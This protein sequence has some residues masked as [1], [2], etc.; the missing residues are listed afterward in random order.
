MMKKLLFVL[1]LFA[2]YDI[3]IANE[4]NQKMNFR[5]EIAERIH[6]ECEEMDYI[7]FY[8]IYFS[9]GKIMA[10]TEVLEMID[11]GLYIL[12]EDIK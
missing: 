8:A 7:G 3:L 6:D 9:T 12:P 2:L 5:Q 4:Q 1:Y 11:S 10:Y